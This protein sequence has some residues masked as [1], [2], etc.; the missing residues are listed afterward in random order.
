MKLSKIFTAAI[1][2]MLA[3]STVQAAEIPRE[4]APLNAT[5]EQIVIV[6]NLI[7]DILDE[8]ALGPVSY[9]HLDVYKRQAYTVLC[10]EHIQINSFVP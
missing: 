9:T 5:E 3:L 1:T 7:G 8:V 10:N 2:A 6:E 4:S